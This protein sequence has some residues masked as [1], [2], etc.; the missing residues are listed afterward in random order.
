MAPE[1]KR[2]SNDNSMRSTVPIHCKN[3]AEEMSQARCHCT[4]NPNC[5]RAR[6]KLHIQWNLSKFKFLHSL[7]QSERSIYVRT[8]QKNT[9][10]SDRRKFTFAIKVI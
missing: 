10:K 9:L 8:K 3:G 5:E 7:A 6:A 4:P 1:M 2:I